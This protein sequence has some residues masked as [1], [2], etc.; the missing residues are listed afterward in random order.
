MAVGGLEQFLSNHSTPLVHEK[1]ARVSLSQQE[2]LRCC[3]GCVLYFAGEDLK[4]IHQGGWVAWKKPE[5]S[6]AAGGPLFVKDAF[7]NFMCPQRPNTV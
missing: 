6:A 1:L 2:A 4:K 5:D 3:C 7:Y